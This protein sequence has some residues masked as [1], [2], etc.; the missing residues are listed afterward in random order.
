MVDYTNCYS[1]GDVREATGAKPPT[2]LSQLGGML[3][4]G[5]KEAFVYF[6]NGYPGYNHF[7]TIIPETDGTV[8]LIDP[9]GEPFKEK[10]I[11]TIQNKLGITNEQIFY[12]DENRQKISAKEYNDNP[13]PL[14]MFQRDGTR[15]EVGVE[16]HD[17]KSCGPLCSE[18]V[19]QHNAG[20]KIQDVLKNIGVDVKKGA[21]DNQV[22][23]LK[24]IHKKFPKIIK[25]KAGCY[26]NKSFTDLLME[27]VRDLL[28]PGESKSE[29]RTQSLHE[30]YKAS[31]ANKKEDTADAD[32]GINEQEL[33]SKIDPEFGISYKNGKIEFDRLPKDATEE[34]KERFL[35][36]LS[37][38][39]CLK[40]FDV[41][42]DSKREPE[43]SESIT[44]AE[45]IG[46]IS[47]DIT[48]ATKEEKK[49]HYIS[50]ALIASKK[51]GESFK[52]ATHSSSRGKAY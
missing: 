8:T 21:S 30:Y 32:I 31:F 46:L 23:I 29:E 44:E 49:E 26:I 15:P 6:R 17:A 51:S 37:K 16:N 3:A 13:V 22:D 19:R 45:K 11:R 28:Y 24:G 43:R 41:S 35:E 9:Y 12:L 1:T 36:E 25:T 52:D 10:E 42:K 20:I 33:I 38:E 34:E 27:L 2:S 18:I 47:A 5:K 50:E 39:I 4:S 48:K 40:Q 14:A 7:V